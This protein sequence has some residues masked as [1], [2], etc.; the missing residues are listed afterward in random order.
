[1]QHATSSTITR[2]RA[3]VCVCVLDEVQHPCGNMLLPA[4]LSAVYNVSATPP[5]CRN[6]TRIAAYKKASAARQKG[7]TSALLPP[8]TPLNNATPPCCAITYTDTQTH[9]PSQM[10]SAYTFVGKD[11]GGETLPP[12]IAA[13]TE[14]LAGRLARV[15]GVT[16][17]HSPDRPA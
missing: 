3:R 11:L 14:G 8:W 15:G 1:M 4:P 16:E 12:T 13:A 7:D 5:R 2:A 6:T 9:I 17:R 10:K